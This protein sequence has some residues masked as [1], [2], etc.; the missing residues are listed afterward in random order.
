VQEAGS[1]GYVLHAGLLLGFSFDRKDKGGTFFRNLCG[2]LNTTCS[3]IPEGRNF[4]TVVW[5]YRKI[6]LEQYFKSLEN[7]NMFF[8]SYRKYLFILLDAV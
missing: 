5:L 6:C 8:K 3:Y 4:E 2:L 7:N 1:A